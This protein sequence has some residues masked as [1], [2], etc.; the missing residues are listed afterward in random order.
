M[1]RRQAPYFFAQVAAGA[2]PAAVATVLMY[3][4]GHGVPELWGL[5]PSLVVASGM[6]SMLA[7]MGIVGA[8]QDALDG[9]YLTA[10]ARIV[11]L[12]MRTGGLILGVA[13]VLWLGVRVGAPAYLSPEAVPLPPAPLQVLAAATFSLVFAIG[14]RLG[15]RGVLLAAGCGG[16][17]WTFYLVS[18]PLVGADHA[19]AAGGAATVMAVVAHIASS[20]L[21]LPA[22]ALVTLGI[23]P[24][25]PG[26]LLYRGLFRLVVGQPAV[27]PGDAAG[28][29]LL[30]AALTGVALA[31]GSSVGSIVGRQLALPTE[32]VAR[33][34]AVAS[35]RRG[36]LRR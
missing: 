23:A 31:L 2:L 24:L 5:S 7:G 8:A 19:V 22:I 32:R 28:E 16:L 21:R 10:N 3:L 35:L 18:L 9:Y 11:D 15:P 30:M 33:L 1:T 29:L 17:G 4:R 26:M 25:M 20:R 13:G 34:A 36:R 12:M 14:G 6:V 27:N